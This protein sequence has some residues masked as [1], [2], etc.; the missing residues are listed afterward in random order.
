MVDV[1][2]AKTVPADFATRCRER[3]ATAGARPFL[4]FHDLSSGE[5]IELSYTTFGNWL[6]KTGNLIQDDLLAGPGDR[7]ALL[8]RPHWLT[9]VWAVA[10]LL[11]GVTVD[12]WGDPARAHTVVAGPDSLDAARA[13]PGERMALSLLPLGRAFDVVPAGFQ[14]FS[15]EVRAHGDR[16]ASIN[17]PTA[18]TPALV[19]GP[20]TLSHRE[21][22]AAATG[23]DLKDGDRL[24]VTAVRDEFTA[25]QLVDW[26]YAPLL[27][28]ASVV[29]VRG[30]DPDAVERIADVERTTRRVSIS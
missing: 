22:V 30:D 24:L 2:S 17:A 26:L 3:F 13:C 29:L 25:A 19:V 16:F 21:L 27:A 28:G 8:A 6:A 12:V 7:V 23:G 10:P 20:D 1:D 5:R 9:A 18:D 14:D 15:A 11:T 4:T